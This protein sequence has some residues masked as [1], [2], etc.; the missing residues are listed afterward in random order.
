MTYD[1]WSALTDTERAAVRD[2]WNAYGPGYW[3]ALVE[4]ATSRF[5]AEFS[6]TPHVLAID[7]GLYHGGLLIISVHTDLRYPHKVP[8]PETYVGFPVYQFCAPEPDAYGSLTWSGWLW[9]TLRAGL[10]RRR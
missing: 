3:H 8:L 9:R 4:E 6:R 1:E 5:R 10:R 7:H 2:R